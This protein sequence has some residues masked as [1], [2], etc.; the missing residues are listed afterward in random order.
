MFSGP[1]VILAFMFVTNARRKKTSFVIA[2]S[3]F[4]FQELQWKCM[5]AV[6]TRLE[7][8]QNARPVFQSCALPFT[9]NHSMFH[10]KFVDFFFF[11]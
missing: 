8:E 7:Q 3:L 6:R 2:M 11:F 1:F 5:W 9:F 10:Q 4:I